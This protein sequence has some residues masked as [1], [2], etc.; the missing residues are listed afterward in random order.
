MI[1]INSVTAL[2]F[3]DRKQAEQTLAALSVKDD[4]ARPRCSTATAA[5][6]PATR[7][8]AA[9]PRPTPRPPPAE[10]SAL[11]LADLGGA[12][13]AERSGAVGPGM[14]LYRAIRNNGELIGAVM[15]EGEQ[16]QMWLA[17]LRNLGAAGAATAVS[18]VIALLMAARFK[19][20]IAE[21]ISKLIGAAQLVSSSQSY[22]LRVAHQRSDELGSLIDSFNDMLAQIEGRDSSWRSTATSSNARSACAPSSWRRP[23]TPPRRQPGEERLPGHHE[24]RD[25]HADERRAGHDRAAAGHPAERAAAHYTGMVKRSASICW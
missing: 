23:R 20:S 16:T 24:P 3:A 9:T 2:L 15:I 14:R 17:V 25:P 7:R 18:F 21:P 19:G 8:P 13:L 5:C 1:G 10:L 11:R 4:I 6:S 12:E 22:T